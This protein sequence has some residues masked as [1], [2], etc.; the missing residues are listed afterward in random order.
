MDLPRV[1]CCEN[2]L[3]W[4][5]AG[6]GAYEAHCPSC[7]KL[8]ITEGPSVILR[9]KPYTIVVKSPEGPV[10]AGAEDDVLELTFWVPASEKAMLVYVTV[11]KS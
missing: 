3:V 4:E 10:P 5:T 1:E 11:H 6:S 8:V 9:P 7:E 2:V